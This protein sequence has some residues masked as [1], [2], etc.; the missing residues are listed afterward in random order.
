MTRGTDKT[1]E[2]NPFHIRN[3]IDFANKIPFKGCR[4]KI[5]PKK[6][7]HIF[8]INVNKSESLGPEQNRV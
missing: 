8:T 3:L 4:G 6:M 5:P 7:G 2:D 1:E